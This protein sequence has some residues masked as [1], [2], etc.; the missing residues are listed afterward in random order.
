MTHNM[1]QRE[2]TDRVELSNT[3][4]NTTQIGTE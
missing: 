4:S 1:T 2:V 3:M